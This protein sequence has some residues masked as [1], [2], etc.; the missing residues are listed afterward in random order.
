KDRPGDAEKV[1]AVRAL[2]RPLDGF[3]AVR[4]TEQPRNRGLA[5]SVIAGVSEALAL[6]GKVIAVE[7]DLVSSP[8]FLSYMNEA[9]DAYRADRR[10]FSVS[11]YAFPIAVPP[12]YPHDVYL[13]HRSSSWGWGT[14]QDRW[15]KV[16]WKVSDFDSFMSDPRAQQEFN[17]GGDD[18]TAM[19]GMQM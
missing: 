9:L 10:V 13:A 16:D 19:L 2:L 7:D 14:W 8:H 18:L 6:R 4:L 12:S 5:N 3:G 17:R 11:G 15:A 1:A